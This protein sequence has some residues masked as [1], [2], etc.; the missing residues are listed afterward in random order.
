MDKSEYRRERHSVTPALIDGLIGT[1]KAHIGD[2]AGA[3]AIVD[4]LRRPGA[5]FG[6]LFAAQIIE[7]Q[8]APPRGKAT[9]ERA[10]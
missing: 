1:I 3:R 8:L 6:A 5:P 7:D 9:R 4:E 2:E 10:A